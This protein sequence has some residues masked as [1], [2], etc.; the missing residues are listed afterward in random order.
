M[1]SLKKKDSSSDKENESDMDEITG[2]LKPKIVGTPDANSISVTRKLDFTDLPV[3]LRLRKHNKMAPPEKEHKNTEK[4]ASKVGFGL[5][6][7]FVPRTVAMLNSGNFA[8]AVYDPREDG[9][10]T[11]EDE[12]MLE[13][14]MRKSW[15]KH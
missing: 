10:V 3:M 6:K 11:T 9:I 14:W 4:D 2:N 1:D 7:G 8:Q 13:K 12:E 5:G 15:D